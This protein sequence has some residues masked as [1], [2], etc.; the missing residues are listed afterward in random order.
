MRKSFPR[1]ERALAMGGV[2]AL[3]GPCLKVFQRFVYF[4]CN[5]LICLQLAGGMF[6]F[7]THA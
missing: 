6:V 1:T 2:E 3:N 7:D 4:F 5:V